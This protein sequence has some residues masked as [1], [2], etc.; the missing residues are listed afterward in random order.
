MF[1]MIYNKGVKMAKKYTPSAHTVFYFKEKDFIATDIFE[2][3]SYTLEDSYFNRLR[4]WHKTQHL[5]LTDQDKE[6]LE[7][8]LLVDHQINKGEWAGDDL[9]WLCYLATRNPDSMT[10][11]IT[12]EEASQEMIHF[13]AQQE[14]APERPPFEGEC[15]PLPQPDLDLLQESDFYQVLKKRMTTRNFTA[16][17]ITINQ[18]STLLFICFGYIHGEQWE[19]IEAAGLI[20]MG[21]RKSSPSSTG[22]QACEAYI[23]AQHVEGLAAGMY[24]YNP[25]NH[26]L[27]VIR[28]GIEQDEFKRITCDQFWIR[29][30]A[31]GLFIV[32]DS[33]RIFM[34]HPGPRAL[35]LGYYEAGHLSQ[36]ALLTA[37]ALGLRTWLS[38]TIR[39]QYVC[40]ILKLDSPRCFAVTFLTFG[41]GPNDPVP[42]KIKALLNENQSAS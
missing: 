13:A 33:T 7:A 23:A 3:N 32:F 31:C 5:P 42:E 29:E 22:F 19:E 14:A 4:D 28:P 25:K 20:N 37:T 17:A 34:K 30:A 2:K 6:L 16:Q 8:H 40:D 10:P 27:Y 35:V 11:S 15:V 36:T 9:S 12:D 26:S 38:A 39:D 41:H 18:L 24:R 21:E 1:F